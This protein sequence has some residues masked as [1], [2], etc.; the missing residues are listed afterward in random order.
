VAALRR[1]TL[2]VKMED[3]AMETLAGRFTAS[4]NG[5]DV[6]R[7]QVMVKPN[8]SAIRSCFAGKILS[9]PFDIVT[10]IDALVF[11][12]SVKIGSD[13]VAW[14]IKDTKISRKQAEAIAE[15]MRQQMIFKNVYKVHKDSPF[16]GDKY[17]FYKFKR[18]SRRT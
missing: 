13:A 18:S 16:V 15:S 11:P 8:V 4:P 6:R 3:P 1:K 14:I 5:V 2:P 17:T 10:L 9:S 12:L 7:R